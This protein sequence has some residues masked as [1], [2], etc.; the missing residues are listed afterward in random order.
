MSKKDMTIDDIIAWHIEA[1]EKLNNMPVPEN[2]AERNDFKYA[3]KKNKL[4][5]YNMECLLQAKYIKHLQEKDSKN[6]KRQCLNN[7]CS[8]KIIREKAESISLAPVVQGIE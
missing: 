1:H 6:I 2:K 3:M 8:K 4:Q 7:P 5:I